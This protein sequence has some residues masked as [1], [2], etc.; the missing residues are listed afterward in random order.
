M[1]SIFVWRPS[2]SP[3]PSLR[4]HTWPRTEGSCCHRRPCCCPSGWGCR[5]DT[6]SPR[7]RPGRSG[8]CWWGTGSA[9][10]RTLAG[11]LP[12]QRYQRY[13]WKHHLLKKNCDKAPPHG[14]WIETNV[15]KSNNQ[16]QNE[17]LVLPPLPPL[18]PPGEDAEDTDGDD[19]PG[20]E[21]ES[22]PHSEKYPGLG[23][24]HHQQLS[25]RPLTFSSV[26]SIYLVISDISINIIHELF[27]RYN[28]FI[29]T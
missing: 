12:G 22:Q 11:Q 14:G 24:D 20:Q 13:L 5:W 1:N 10:R 23:L 28:G 18:V 26:P 2:P 29:V 4:H 8:R 15:I 3:S 27:P 25:P 16:N 6:P 21:G 17:N 19:N 9:E 7:P